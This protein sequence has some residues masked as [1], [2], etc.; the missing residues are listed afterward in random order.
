M[1]SQC[2]ELHWS[3]YY[4]KT[5]QYLAELRQPLQEAGDRNRID[6]QWENTRACDAS[7]TEWC[8]FDGVLSRKGGVRRIHETPY[9][10]YK[11]AGEE[12]Q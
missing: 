12:I 6:G 3:F 8:P 5:C 2:C 9:V 10:V 1:R 7:F 4:Y 11:K